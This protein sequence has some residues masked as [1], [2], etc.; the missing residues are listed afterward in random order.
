MG[1]S[2]LL[3]SYRCSCDANLAAPKC[4]FNS[5]LVDKC[6]PRCS[7]LQAETCSRVPKT[8]EDCP[9]PCVVQI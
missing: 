6:S 1:K 7:G 8:P 4:V 9:L 2:N 3:I 5:T